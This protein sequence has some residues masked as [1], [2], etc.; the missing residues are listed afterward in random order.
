MKEI[1]IMSEEQ[2][3]EA[4]ETTETSTETTSFLDSISEGVR[5][6]SLSKFNSIDDLAQSYVNLEKKLGNS[7]SIP[8]EDASTEAREDF[9]SRMANIPGVY[10][11]PEDDVGKAA[12]FQKLGKP[13]NKDQ[14]NFSEIITEDLLTA[15]PHFDEEA[16]AF[17]DIAFDLNLTNDQVN[18]LAKMRAEGEMAKHQAGIVAAQDAQK[19]LQQDWGN[20]FST[21]MQ[22]VGQVLS[23]FE[24]EYPDAVN[25]LKHSVAG[26]NVVLIKA[27]AQ[28]ADQYK[29]SSVAGTQPTTFGMTPEMART[30]IEELKSDRG[31]MER[32]LGAGHLGH[33]EAVEK[34]TNLTKIAFGG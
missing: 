31:F 30:K 20:E 14:Y 23:S 32:Y 7:I 29:E 2:N 13:E 10:L 33:N 6:E 25:E 3:I 11:E 15:S 24:K 27:F 4:S 18:E 12:L 5:S 9:L 21:K 22:A 17:K 26:N 34:Y 1:N 8:S 19:Q 16:E 28:L